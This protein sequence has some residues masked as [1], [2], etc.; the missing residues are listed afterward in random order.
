M[1]GVS[2][3][4]KR[5]AKLVVYRRYKELE[6]NGRCALITDRYKVIA[7]SMVHLA[8]YT[9]ENEAERWQ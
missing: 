9:T 2:F 1:A 8:P 3:R 6:V 7:K 4:A 5:L